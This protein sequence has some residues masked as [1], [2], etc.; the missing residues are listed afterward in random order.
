MVKKI[1]GNKKKFK[2]IFFKIFNFSLMHNLY[3]LLILF[4][5]FKIPK[6]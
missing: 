3:Y 2:N 5:Q 1:E 4:N 6:I